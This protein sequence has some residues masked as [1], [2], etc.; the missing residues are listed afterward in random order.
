MPSLDQ[1]DLASIYTTIYDH[2]YRCD[3]MKMI[4]TCYIGVQKNPYGG[5]EGIIYY[6][7]N[8]MV[9]VSWCPNILEYIESS[10]NINKIKPLRYSKFNRSL[11]TL[12]SLD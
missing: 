8:L 5:A 9:F 3:M 2:T 12:L 4:T 1:T 10:M 6:S 11:K 7:T